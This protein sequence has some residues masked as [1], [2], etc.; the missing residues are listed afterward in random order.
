MRASGGEQRPPHVFCPD[1]Q[2]LLV[3]TARRPS[4]LASIT[5]ASL[6]DAS[7]KP[8]PPLEKPPAAASCPMP[9]LEPPMLDDVAPPDPDVALDPDAPV[10]PVD[11]LRPPPCATDESMPASR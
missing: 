3:S 7:M 1:T 5:S 2:P 6:P 10:P 4:P 9:P 8:P 11:P